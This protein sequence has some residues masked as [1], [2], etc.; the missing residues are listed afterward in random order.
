MVDEDGFGP[1]RSKFKMKKK[2]QAYP[3][4]LLYELVKKI[5]SAGVEVSQQ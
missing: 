3:V 2:N 5:F 1:N 4:P